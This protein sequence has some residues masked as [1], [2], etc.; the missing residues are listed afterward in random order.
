MPEYL[1][2]GVY[3]E[4]RSFRSKSI[5]G[6]STST[7]GFVGPARYG[8]IDGEPELMTSFGQFERIY[9]GLDP[10]VYAEEVPNF[11]AHAVRAFFDNGGS[12]L[13]IAR[14]FTTSDIDGETA[15]VAVGTNGLVIDARFP[16]AAGD[17]TVEVTGRVG[18]DVLS[19]RD[20]ETVVDQ[21]RNGDLVVIQT[22]GTALIHSATRTNDVWAFEPATGA[23]IGLGDLTV[24]TDHV[25]PLT[26]TVEITLPGEFLQQKLWAGLTVSDLPGRF[27]DS[28]SQVFASD[29][30][31]RMQ[32]LETPII[33]I[34]SATARAAQ[35]AGDLMDL[36]DWNQHLTDGELSETATLVLTGGG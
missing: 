29:I 15:S 21:L 8:P 17:M 6:V 30:T 10:L 2:P 12:R 34:P 9:G 31:N 28:A 35:I 20:G 4:E 7:T 14:A 32:R 16:G 18:A 36:D 33:M 27:R 19:T 13:Y 3:V 26:L 23:A 22:G 5:E 1:S 25:F 24:N 11:L